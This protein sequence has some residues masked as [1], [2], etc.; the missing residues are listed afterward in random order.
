M[1]QLPM[2]HDTLSDALRAVVEA[3]GPKRVAGELWRLKPVRDAHRRLLHRLDDERDEKL[4]IA[5]IE[6]ILKLGRE[7]GVHTAVAYIGQTCGYEFTPVEPEDERA[8]LQ[9]EFV[10][11]TKTLEVLAKRIERV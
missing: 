5:E 1:N 2:W 7:C 11:A 8:K 10:E 4:A 6:H 3:V 9:R